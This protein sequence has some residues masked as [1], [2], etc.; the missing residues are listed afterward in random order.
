MDYRETLKKAPLFAGLSQA[1]IDA[2]AA[3]TVRKGVVKGELLFSEGDKAHG[4]YIVLKGSVKIFK[5]SAAG[6]EQVLHIERPVHSFAEIPLFDG[7]PYPASAAAAEDSTLLFLDK[8]SFDDLCL[9]HPRIALSVIRLIG[10]RLRRLTHLIEEISL[11]DVSHRLA[12][13]LLE[14]ARTIGKKDNRGIEFELDASHAEIA[15]Q[16]G[17]VREVVSRTLSRLEADGLIS[18][19]GRTLRIEDLERLQS[20]VSD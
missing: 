17:T 4:L 19:S 18:T 13:W 2:L 7:G 16:I 12:W 15:S 9:S 1:E 14:K 5:M 11:R 20:M 8:K 6:R 10:G 3:R